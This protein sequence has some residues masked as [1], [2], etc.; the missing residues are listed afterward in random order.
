MVA[1]SE[2]DRDQ[3]S[4]PNSMTQVDSTTLFYVPL[5][6]SS[7]ALSSMI[8]KLITPPL[9][10]DRN[11]VRSLSFSGRRR[12]S[13]HSDIDLL[14]SLSPILKDNLIN[15][16]SSG[17][18][19]NSAKD[20]STKH[21][22]YES[23]S[24]KSSPLTLKRSNSLSKTTTVGGPPRNQ[25]LSD[26]QRESQATALPTTSVSPSHKHHHHHRASRE[27]SRQKQSKR[28][29]LRQLWSLMR[30]QI[31]LGMV[32]S[33][34]PVKKD[35]PNTKE[36]LDAAGIRFVY[37]SPQNMK[38]SKSVAEKIGIPFDWNC[39]ISLRELDSEQHDPHR[40]ISNYADWDVL[41]KY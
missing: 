38:R 20:S 3:S 25:L 23:S 4:L 16:L 8:P 9:E 22:P 41:G 17:N 39:A 5:S 26:D 29:A 21:V 24:A 12:S 27:S 1:S 11:M 31:F 37:F 40:H 7:D 34:V 10:G 6:P 35:V 18:L 36:D 30:Q 13:S 2:R 15:N 32:A 14:A 28:L 19:A 33:S